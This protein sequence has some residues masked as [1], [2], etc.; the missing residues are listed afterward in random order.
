[1]AVA[2]RSRLGY[3]SL[4][5]S[6]YSFGSI[7]SNLLV[8]SMKRANAYYDAMESRCYD[9]DLKFLEEE[10]PLSP[11]LAAGAVLYTAALFAVWYVTG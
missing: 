4:K 2:A 8:V 3:R 1:M 10:K 9:G 11:A 6:W 5:T 7:F